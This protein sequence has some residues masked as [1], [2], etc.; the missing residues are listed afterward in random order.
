MDEF[1]VAIAFFGAI[2]GLI[3]FKR[4]V[5]NP[6]IKKTPS[7]LSIWTWIKRI[8]YLSL[9]ML[10]LFATFERWYYFHD[11]ISYSKKSVE[12]DL[13]YANQIEV[14]GYLTTE[15]NVSG[16][17]SGKEP[18]P[19]LFQKKKG[20][21]VFYKVIRIKNTGDFP[22]YG[23]LKS[24]DPKRFQRINVPPLPPR[25]SDFKSIVL[26][27]YHFSEDPLNIPANLDFEWESIYKVKG[28]SL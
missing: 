9:S 6:F 8:T 25:M 13:S 10:L 2:I 11:D 21:V 5:F 23:I 12:V 28:S 20:G 18:F 4:R 19:R 1:L 3:F 17:F 7:R 22:I 14:E 24:T 16:V 27:G 15:E 26:W